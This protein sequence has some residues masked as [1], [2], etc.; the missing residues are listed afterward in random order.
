MQYLKYIFFKYSDLLFVNDTHPIGENIYGTFIFFA[1]NATKKDNILQFFDI[2]II[3]YSLHNF[4][5]VI[6]FIIGNKYFNFIEL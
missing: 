2:C 5:K 3:S 6:G 1:I 4:I